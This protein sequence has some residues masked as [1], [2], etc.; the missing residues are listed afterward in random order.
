MADSITAKLQGLDPVLKRMRTLAPNLQKKGLAAAV[1]KGA[2][3]FRDAAKQNATRIDDPETSR[4][5]V[6]NIA[7]QSSA[8]QGRREGGVVYRTGVL[9]GARNEGNR[10]TGGGSEGTAGRASQNPGGDTW[11]WRMVE[12]GTSMVAARP[13]LLP[14]MVN[15]LDRATSVVVAELNRQIDKLVP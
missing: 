5:I 6:K 10:A 13:F 3:V 12:L 7:T 15:N 2:F 11:Y 8:R 9:G 4:Q 14:A 1:R